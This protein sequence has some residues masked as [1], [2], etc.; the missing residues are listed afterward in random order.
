MTN[1][2]IQA[3]KLELGVAEHCNLACRSCSH[4]SPVIPKRNMD[5]LTLLEDLT[6]L[7]R[8]YHAH[9][10]SLIGGEPLL[11]PNLV[12]IFDAIR[13]SEVGDR[14]AVATNGV[15][16]PRMKPEFWQAVDWVEVSQY[17]GHSLTPD[18]QGVCY[19]SAAESGTGIRFVS[20]REF[21]QAYSEPGTQDSALSQAI[22]DSCGIVHVWRCHTLAAGRFFKCPQSYYLSHIIP[23]VARHVT[24]DSVL[25]RDTPS[26]AEELRAYL[27]S[28]IPLG[29]CGHCLGT[30]GRRFPHSQ[31]SR[32]GFRELQMLTA[33][34]LVDPELLAKGLPVG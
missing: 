23:D 26:F 32:R 14:I 15:L 13:Q 11:H 30:A 4:V 29:A 7:S 12:D 19:R 20:R 34:E 9:V 2:R 16:L 6:I 3:E 24:T 5:P 33:E 27:D 1:E 31:V 21:R 8:V 28:T 10:V 25:I 17:P 22:F 18:Q